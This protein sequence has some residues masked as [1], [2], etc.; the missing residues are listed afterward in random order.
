MIERQKIVDLV[1]KLNEATIDEK[2]LWEK[3]KPPN[4]LIRGTEDVITSCF[5]TVDKSTEAEIY[6]YERRHKRDAMEL[7][8][9]QTAMSALGTL[10]GKSAE[11]LAWSSY[12]EIC[13]LDSSEEIILLSN[14]KQSL[15]QD[16]HTSVKVKTLKIDGVINQIIE[17]L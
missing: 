3:C 13:I 4:D 7:F 10:Y 17:G 14:D 2:R 16:L 8:Q 1:V 15:L 12:K 11:P 5:K 9:T 6:I